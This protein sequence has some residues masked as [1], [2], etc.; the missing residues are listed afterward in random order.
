MTYYINDLITHYHIQQVSEFMHTICI[1]VEEL[2]YWKDR[3]KEGGNKT[4][5]HECCKVL[6][7]AKE[8]KLEAAIIVAHALDV[9]HK[10]FSRYIK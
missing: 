7:L 4:M 5:W 6:K 1:P 2:E 10:T 3:F 8:K 9:I